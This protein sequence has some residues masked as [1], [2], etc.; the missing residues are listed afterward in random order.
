MGDIDQVSS[1]LGGIKSDIANLAKGHESI[2]SKLVI[3]D[4]K[5]SNHAVS[6]I[7]DRAAIDSLHKRMDAIEPIVDDHADKFKFVAWAV[8]GITS[9]ITLILNLV[10]SLLGRVFP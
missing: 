7:L 8:A 9:I 5:L 6:R 3:I 10:P 4:D 1:L 2:T